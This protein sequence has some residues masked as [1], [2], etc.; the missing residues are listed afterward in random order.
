MIIHRKTARFRTPLPLECGKS[1]PQFELAYE[2]YGELNNERSNAVLICHGLTATQNAAGVPKNDNGKEAK[3]GWWD[4]AIG[5]GKP[6]D[7]SRFYV[8]CI[9]VPGSFGGSTSPASTNPATGKPYGMTFPVVTITDMVDAQKHLADRLGI[10]KFYA[11]AGGCMGGFQVLEWMSRYPG[12]LSRAVI[13]STTPRV[14]AHTIALWSVLREAIR[15]DPAWNSGDYYGGGAPDRGMGLAA[16]IGA[17]FWMNRQT[18]EK[19]FGLRPL[20]EKTPGY[21]FEPEFE[22]EAFLSQVN[23]NAARKIDAN[24]LIYLTRAM[25]YFNMTRGGVELASL[26]AGAQYHALLVSYKSDWRYPPQEAEEIH[27]ALRAASIDSRHEI[28]DSHFGHGAFIYD[29]HGLGPVVRD[30][31]HNPAHSKPSSPKTSAGMK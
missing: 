1:L 4:I 8:I 3:P 9:N 27:E 6:I 5:P 16:A 2:S 29:F 31:L 13:I 30:F 12:C 25:D 11:I 21:G 7:T 23:Q 17:L 28:L 26:F 10:K 15:S 24:A 14:S 18:M 20:D 22:V 19:K